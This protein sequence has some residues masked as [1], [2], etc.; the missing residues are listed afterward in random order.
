MLMTRKLL[1][2]Y[3][4][5][6]QLKIPGDLFAHCGHWAVRMHPDGTT[7]KIALAGPQIWGSNN[8]T[9]RGQ[10]CF[11]GKTWVMGSTGDVIFS[12]GGEVITGKPLIVAY[13][14]PGMA[15]Y[16]IT[17]IGQLQ[18]EIVRVVRAGKSAIAVGLSYGWDMADYG[19]IVRTTGKRYTY[20]QKMLYRD[21]G[22]L[23]STSADGVSWSDGRI[24]L[25]SGVGHPDRWDLSRTFPPEA[26]ISFSPTEAPRVGAG[27]GAAL[28]AHRFGAAVQEID[29]G[30]STYP[31]PPTW[32]Y[33]DAEKHPHFMVSKD[34]GG[35]G[36]EATLSQA[37]ADPYGGSGIS[38]FGCDGE[39]YWCEYNGRFALSR[40]GTWQYPVDNISIYSKSG[41]KLSGGT[42]FDGTIGYEEEVIGDQIIK[43]KF[44]AVAILSG[45]YLSVYKTYDWVRFDEMKRV[46]GL[47]VTGYGDTSISF[48]AGYNGG[49]MLSFDNSS[50]PSGYKVCS[51]IEDWL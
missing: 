45:T 38:G 29:L 17:E 33:Q 37:P 39:N 2:G 8:G 20:G 34:G 41:A 14:L 40:G 13:D 49:V 27:G 24:P 9:A 26:G 15:T 3:W 19:D 51:K 35:F 31:F 22:L 43:T 11:V 5:D 25:P 21:C 4:G 46:S 42:L 10:G 28:I 16:T 50:G 32:R 30:A 1:K 23:M 6:E 18:G 7:Q 12:P 47:N 36:A 44:F 48:S